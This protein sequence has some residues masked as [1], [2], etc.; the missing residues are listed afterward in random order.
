MSR[1]DSD[2][3]ERTGRVFVREATGLVKSVSLLDAFS[4][5]LGSMSVGPAL[6]TIGATMVLVPSVSGLN[7]V[8]ASLLSA[9]FTIPMVVV[10]V[11]M[12]GRM[13]RTGGD[14]VWIS[15]EFGGLFGGSLALS[16]F[17]VA[18]MAFAALSAIAGVF[19][20]GSV[21]VQLGNLNFLGLA[22]PNGIK[23]SNP[24]AQVS[25][26]AAIFVV[27]FLINIL[28][29]KW[30]LR[31]ASGMMIFTLIALFLAIAVL[32]SAG[33]PGVDQ[34]VSY[35]NASGANVTYNSVVS[36]YSG[37]SF[38]L[39]NTLFILPFFSIFAYPYFNV[40]P[41]M[42]SEFRGRNT[43][44]YAIPL[45]VILG[46]ITLTLGFGAMYY[47]A[48]I[49]F[50]NSALSNSNLV[51]DYSFNFWTLAM[52]ATS[53]VVLQYII[54]LGWIVGLMLLVA[55]DM[56][57]IPRY[58][59]G[60]SFDRFLPQKMAEVNSR[61]G[62][63]VYA[64]ATFALI[65]FVMAALATY[66]YGTFVSL[67]GAV[68]ATMIFFVFVGLSAVLLGL[69]SKSDRHRYGLVAAGVLM[70]AV[71]G[72]FAYDFFAYPTVWGGNPLAYGFSSVAFVIGIVLYLTMRR[73]LSKEGIDLSLAFKEIPPE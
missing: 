20:I 25:V 36:S 7:L 13:S 57:V 67:Y 68:A 19:A 66:L 50:T 70:A 42:G 31:V 16:G 24:A 28:R 44:R 71:F 1:T 72:Y 39:N 56:V 37:S 48:G 34:Y 4:I 53:S 40:G 6:G 15:R 64:Q 46:A 43:G 27:L 61:F 32:F 59:F 11:M 65:A 54:G 41:A 29:P 58:L 9:L 62:S 23:G 52:G 55:V 3:D 22:L 8:Y 14:Y 51:F 63:P 33:R 10:Y 2:G 30:G 69:K 73:R 45:A 26:I 18:A 38:N 21:G 12:L 5:N 49:G 60:M 17:V 47:A 35:L